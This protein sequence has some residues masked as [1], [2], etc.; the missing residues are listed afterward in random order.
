MEMDGQTDRLIVVLWIDRQTERQ[1]LDSCVMVDRQLYRQKDAVVLDE[2]GE[3]KGQQKQINSRLI[4]VL[5]KWIGRQME[6]N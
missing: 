3:Q 1:R 5:Q 2:I 6:R 4:V